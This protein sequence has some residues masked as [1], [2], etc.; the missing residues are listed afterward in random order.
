ML[1]RE[2]GH[3]PLGAADGVVALASTERPD[4]IVADFNLPNGPNG[5]E[6]IAQLREKFHR[7]IP[8]IVITGDISTQTLRAIAEFRQHASRQ[9]G[10]DRGT[11]ARRDESSRCVEANGDDWNQ[12]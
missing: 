9:A 2:A 6:V 10:R 5:V 4:L 3:R 11:V 1:L 8:A 7:E 12:R